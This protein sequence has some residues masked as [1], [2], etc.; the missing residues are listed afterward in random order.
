MQLGRRGLF[1]VA[2]VMAIL[3]AAV[4]VAWQARWPPG[5]FGGKA[6]QGLSE[7]AVVIRFTSD[8]GIIL[9]SPGDRYQLA[10]QAETVGGHRKVTTVPLSQIVPT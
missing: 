10:A 4:V 7:S 6:A 5:L 2:G 9:A 8:Q 1:T 3:L